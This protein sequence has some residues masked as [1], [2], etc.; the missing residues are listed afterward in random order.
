MQKI[1]TR[2]FIISSVA[3]GVFGILMI[4]TPQEPQLLYTIIQ[5]LLAISLFIVLPSFALAVA[6]RFLNTKH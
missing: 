3:F 4:L 6:A 5:K 1:A 2:V